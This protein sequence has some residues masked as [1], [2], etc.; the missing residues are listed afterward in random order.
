MVEASW[1]RIRYLGV[2]YCMNGSERGRLSYS[3]CGYWL[4]LSM[5]LC[6]FANLN[7]N[8]PISKLGDSHELLPAN[9]NHNQPQHHQTTEKPERHYERFN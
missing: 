8:I 1:P 7:K 5:R 4:V 9:H 3:H 2:R 6:H